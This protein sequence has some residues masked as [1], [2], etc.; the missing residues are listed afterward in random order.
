[1]YAEQATDWH[2]LATMRRWQEAIGMLKGPEITFGTAPT[3]SG[4]ALSQ[5]A[6]EAKVRNRFLEAE[7]AR[8]EK[9]LQANPVDVV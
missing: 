4:F 1:M 2:Y 3:E 6:A 9:E 7:L 8:L 5:L